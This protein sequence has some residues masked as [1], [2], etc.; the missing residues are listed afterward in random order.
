MS[1]FRS[2]WLWLAL[3]FV[4]AGMLPLLLVAMILSWVLLPQVLADIETRHQALARAVSGQVEGHLRSAGRELSAVAEYLQH[5]GD[6]PAPFR[7]EPILDAHAG[8]GEVFAAIYVVDATNTVS[9]LGLPR[10]ER[11]QRGDGVEIDLSRLTFVREARQRRAPVWSE[12]VV[13]AVSS[14]RVSQPRDSAGRSGADRRSR[15]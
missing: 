15:D 1:P 2:L 14:R 10:G 8:S 4:L 6:Q 9:A 3:R 12:I 5:R 7:F 11:Q 13:S